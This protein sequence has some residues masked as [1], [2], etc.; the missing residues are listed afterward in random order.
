MK[1]ELI[2]YYKRAYNDGLMKGTSGN[3]SI[4][5]RDNE[6]IIITPSSLDHSILSE[7]DIV[8]IDM[9]GNVLK[10]EQKPSSEWRMHLE[11]YKKCK[12]ANAILHSHSPF[13]T[14]YAVMN[15]EIPFILAEMGYWT[16]GAIPV[17]KFAKMGSLELGQNAAETLM[18]RRTCL[19]QNHGVLA[20]GENI[21]DAYLRAIYIED[22]AQ[23][24]CIANGMSDIQRYKYFPKQSIKTPTL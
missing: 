12:H 8:E 17:S 3:A 1:A 2:E 6:I 5:D 9:E 11:I 13:A 20:I 21:K 14:A 7:D 18:N 16:D 19:L 10:G 4:I 24:C 15:K 22:A 23:I